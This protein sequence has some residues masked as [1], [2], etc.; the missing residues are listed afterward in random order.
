VNEVLKVD[1]LKTLLAHASANYFRETRGRWAFRGLPDKSYKL[2]PSVGR[3][4]H[5]SGSRQKYES[6]MFAIFEREAPGFLAPIPSGMWERLS[7]AQHHGLP[8]RL[9]DW[10]HNILVSLYFAVE[11]KEKTDGRIFA[12]RA[13]RKVPEEVL[14]SSPFQLAQPEKYYPN[15][16]TPRIRAQEGL[17]VVCAQLET[18]LDQALRK[19]WRIECLEVPAAKKSALRYELYRVGVHQSSMFPDIDGLAARIRWQQSVS[20]LSD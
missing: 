13:P 17:F 18:P 20:P 1:S 7:L 10:T 5:T 2:V 11:A 12:L 6:E 3:G 19:D 4:A 9:L 14:K 15:V 16:V 8:T